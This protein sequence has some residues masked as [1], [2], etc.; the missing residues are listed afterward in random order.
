M[1]SIPTSSSDSLSSTTQVK[2]SLAKSN[3]NKP[4]FLLQ[5]IP[6]VVLI[7]FFYFVIIRPQQ[8]KS[9]ETTKMINEMKIGSKILTSG[10]IYGVI[11][12]FD[13]DSD[14]VKIEISKNVR[15]VIS[16]SSIVSVYKNESES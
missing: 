14:L 5:S 12:E 11:T 13:K 15:I 10:G 3:E 4:N 7:F 9:K 8:K 1:P 2:T 16:K 6:L